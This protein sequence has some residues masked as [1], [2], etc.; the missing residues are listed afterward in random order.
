MM[1]IVSST[2]ALWEKYAWGYAEEVRCMDLQRM[3]LC[4]GSMK[5]GSK[6]IMA[7]LGHC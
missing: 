4:D 6:I 1:Q 7:V 3:C 2:G 5:P